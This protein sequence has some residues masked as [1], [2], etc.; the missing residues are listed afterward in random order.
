MQIRIDDLTSPQVAQLLSEHL[1]DMKRTSPPE[2][3]HALDLGK[4][5]E[6]SVTFW[7]AWE[8][9]DLAGCGAIR[10]LEPTHAEIKSMRTAKPF[11]GQGVASLI[12]KTMMEHAKTRNYHRLSLETGTGEFF[13]PAHHFY[14]KF[15]FEYCEPFS[16]YKP[17][18]FSAFMTI[19][20]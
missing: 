9:S 2:S 5:K 13:E 20:L 3:F 18:A 11:R 4:L 1:D 8:G 7:T 10:E 12:L 17:D 15:G 16:N 6:P 14:K 19:E